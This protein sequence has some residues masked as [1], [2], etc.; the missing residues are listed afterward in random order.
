MIE[1]VEWIRFGA[2]CEGRRAYEAGQTVNPYR[3]DVRAQSWQDGYDEAQAG[4]A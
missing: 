1:Q 2:W 4:R 3:D